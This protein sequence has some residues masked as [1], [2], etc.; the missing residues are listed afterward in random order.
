MD[1]Q[2]TN[3]LSKLG[4]T[5]LISRYANRYAFWSSVFPGEG[6]SDRPLPETSVPGL[7]ELI[8]GDLPGGRYAARTLR[9]EV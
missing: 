5:R 6:I 4:R 1:I 8:Q 2:L 9:T 7:L 3:N